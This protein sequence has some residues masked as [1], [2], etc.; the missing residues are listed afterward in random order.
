[1][2]RALG[3]R[4]SKPETHFPGWTT[5]INLRIDASRIFLMRMFCGLEN[6]RHGR[7][8]YNSSGM[9]M[10]MARRA[11]GRR[12]SARGVSQ[13][14]R[15][16]CDLRCWLTGFLNNCIWI[17][18][19]SERSVHAIRA[20]SHVLCLIQDRTAI[21]WHLNNLRFVRRLGGHEDRVQQVTIVSPLSAYMVGSHQKTLT[22]RLSPVISRATKLCVC[23]KISS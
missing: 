9:E 16:F 17:R 20:S 1:M 10:A 19:E 13:R 2:A 18:G 3:L 23:E 12:I 7:H 8:R 11:Q 14:S 5:N 15:R 6:T 21:V 4:R 22:K